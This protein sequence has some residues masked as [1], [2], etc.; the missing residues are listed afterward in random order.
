[1]EISQT[2]IEAAEPLVDFLRK[3]KHPHAKVIVDQTGAEL[4]EGA[5][6]TGAAFDGSEPEQKDANPLHAPSAHDLDVLLRELKWGRKAAQ[7]HLIDKWI[8]ELTV[9]D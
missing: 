1:M 4:V 6:S 2:L 5:L 3:H 7:Q 9:E 8:A